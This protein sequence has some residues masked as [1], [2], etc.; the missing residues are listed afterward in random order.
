MGLKTAKGFGWTRGRV[1]NFRTDNAIANY[2]PGERQM[3]GELTIDEVAES[4]KAKT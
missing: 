1:G 4:V 3:R 2:T